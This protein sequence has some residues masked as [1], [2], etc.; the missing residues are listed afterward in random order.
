MPAWVF[1]ANPK[2][3]DL[4]TTVKSKGQDWWSAPEYRKEIAVGDSV[5]MSVVGPHEPGIYY[6]ATVT[7]AP[8]LT[9]EMEF[10][11]WRVDLVFTHELDPYLARSEIKADPLLSSCRSL[12]GFQGTAGRLSP[13][14]ETQLLGLARS[15]LKPLDN[16]E[17]PRG[18]DDVAKVV[19]RQRARVRRELRDAIESLSPEG[20]EQFVVRVLRALEFEVVHQGRSG[21][22]GVD[23]EAVLSLR[24]LTSVKTKVQAKRWQHTVGPR[25][26][27]ELRGALRVDE[28]GLVVTTADFT[29]EAQLEARADGKAAIGLLDG[30]GL[31][32]LCIENEIGV[33]LRTLSLP[34]LDRE[35]LN[36]PDT[37]LTE[38]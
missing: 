36:E 17:T 7:G 18:A 25:V 11:K 12:L 37:A 16:T 3:Y 8:Y 5:W 13:A 28:R 38:E 20:F 27:R 29:S 6:L 24:G 4:F 32:D 30:N 26:V 2:L 31:A 1:Q 15:R 19:E 14:E 35:G 22:G 9:E 10:S 34:E 33:K 23:A 21:D